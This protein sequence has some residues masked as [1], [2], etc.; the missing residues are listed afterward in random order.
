MKSYSA[1]QR[2]THQEAWQEADRTRQR[3]TNELLKVLSTLNTAMAQADR[4]LK[5]ATN[6]PALAA[7]LRLSS[8]EE[9]R[10]A[11][12]IRNELV[13]LGQEALHELDV[14]QMP[15]SIGQ[16]GVSFSRPQD[17]PNYQPSGSYPGASLTGAPFAEVVEP[18][19]PLADPAF[20][21]GASAGRRPTDTSIGPPSVGWESPQPTTEDAAGLPGSTAPIYEDFP[22]DVPEEASV[23]A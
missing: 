22:Q 7:S 1:L 17:D 15:Q 9:L 2:A 18:G 6:L 21:Q 13:L 3:A 14:P 16:P 23:E 20:P 8:E 11:Q 4:E 19:G 10:C 12:A 5:E